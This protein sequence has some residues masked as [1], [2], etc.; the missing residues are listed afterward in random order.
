MISDKRRDDYGAFTAAGGGRTRDLTMVS[1]EPDPTS[2][3]SMEEF[4]HWYEEEHVPALA[5]CP[6]WLRSSRWELVDAREP[7]KSGADGVQTGFARL[8]TLHEWEDA[9]VLYASP[10]VKDA[11]TTPW[12]DK[13]IPRCDG[14]TEERRSLRLWKQ[15]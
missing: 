12:R 1:L 3:L 7:R 14:K 15:F 4:H 8:L 9:D 5:K 11:I 6:G 2:N 13:I 10:E